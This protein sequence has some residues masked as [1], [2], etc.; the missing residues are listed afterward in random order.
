[1]NFYILDTDVLTLYQ[2][3]DSVVVGQVM[4]QFWSGLA[5]TVISVE[6]QLSGW[7][8]RLRRAKDQEELA[9]V[10]QRLTDTI[11]SLARFRVLSFTAGA[12][13]R[14]EELRSKKL[15]V[16]KNDLR[17]AAIVLEAGGILATR[18]IRDF[19]RIPGLRIEDWSK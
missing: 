19:H 14:Y 5:V 16:S 1:M 12:I 11:Q 7:Y 10:Y 17:I 4:R 13:R 2:M 6:E 3:G 8:T 9:S 18:N 15:K